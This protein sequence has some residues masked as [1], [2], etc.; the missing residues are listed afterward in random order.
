MLQPE[1]IALIPLIAFGFYRLM[2][3]PGIHADRLLSLRIRMC[4]AQLI[5]FALVPVTF[6]G[7]ETWGAVGVAVPMALGAGLLL[8]LQPEKWRVK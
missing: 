7:H 4:I 3:R 6:F 8:W 1:M 2:L 5:G